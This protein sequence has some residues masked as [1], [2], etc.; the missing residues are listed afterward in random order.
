MPNPVLTCPPPATFTLQDYLTTITLIGAAFKHSKEESVE[1]VPELVDNSA[2]YEI[3]NKLILSRS[4]V[5]R[6]YSVLVKARDVN[7]YEEKCRFSIA[8]KGGMM[9]E[10]RDLKLRCLN[11]IFINIL[12]KHCR[13]S[14]RALEIARRNSFHKDRGENI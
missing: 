4:S 13:G 3:P 12:R 9:K 14:M 2:A 1:Y 7:G 11:S 10:S 6:N 8:V 5:G